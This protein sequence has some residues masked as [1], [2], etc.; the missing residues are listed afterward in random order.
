MTR[1]APAAALALL[2]AGCARDRAA[3]VQEPL[4][5]SRHWVSSLNRDHPLAGKI[6][7]VAGRR[8]V[9]EAALGAA[10]AQADFVLLGETHDN[11]DHHLLQARLVRALAA[12]GRRPTVAFEMLS[13]EQQPAID[14]AVAANPRSADALGKALDW[15][16]GGWPP[17]AM[18]Q[19]IFAAALESGLPIAG[20][21][22]PR[23][24]IR[25]VVKRGLE[26]LPEEVRARIGRQGPLA[27][28]VAL[29]MRDEMRESHCG[30]LPEDL[31]D[32]MVLGQR[33]RDAQMAE[34]L[35]RVGRPAGAV[36]VT[37]A[38]HA[39]TDRGVASYLT[40]DAGGRRIA[41]VVFRE[42]SAEGLEPA[43]Y[44]PPGTKALPYDYVVFTPATDR[45][46]PCEDFRKH[47]KAPPKHTAPSAP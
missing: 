18:Y 47:R 22:L 46:D 38:E 11:P 19:P 2:A 23:K 1:L 33:A 37:G 14:A 36:L 43:A 24:Q 13:T 17:F 44:A 9:D 35:A 7:D 3:L 30:E 41:A 20:A 5:P 42:V 21:N 15:D 28:D 6:W 8:F 16:K 31:L 34:S 40:P 25:E 32:P 12:A 29:A 26:A 10:L 39:R 27:S 4:A 45:S